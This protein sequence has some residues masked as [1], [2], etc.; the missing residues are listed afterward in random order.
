MKLLLSINNNSLFF[1]ARV[2]S[3]FQPRLHKAF[4]MFSVQHKDA[5]AYHGVYFLRNNWGLDVRDG[6]SVEYK[7][8]S[9]PIM[10]KL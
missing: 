6:K 7:G 9:P 1:K 5:G 10:I 3:C 2:Q 8:G 4:V